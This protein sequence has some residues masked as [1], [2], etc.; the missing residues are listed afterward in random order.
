MHILL[1]R[2]VKKQD[3]RGNDDVLAKGYFAKRVK[4]KKNQI[5]NTQISGRLTALAKY[6]P[7]GWTCVLVELEVFLN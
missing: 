5:R 4:D 3:I 6:L 2:P 1:A 7:G